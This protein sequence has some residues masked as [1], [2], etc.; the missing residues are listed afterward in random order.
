MGYFTYNPLNPNREDWQQLNTEKEDPVDLVSE[1]EY[2]D[3]DSLEDG[4]QEDYPDE[5]GEF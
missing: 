3:P 2:I 5:D 4:P 1:D